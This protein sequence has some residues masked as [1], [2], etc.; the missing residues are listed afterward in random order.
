MTPTNGATQNAVA[1][2]A[3]ALA[4]ERDQMLRDFARACGMSPS[5]TREAIVARV[6]EDHQTLARLLPAVAAFEAAA[7]G[8]PSHTH[9][10]PVCK[11]PLCDCL[12]TKN[13][14]C[15]RC[16]KASQTGEGG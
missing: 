5:D 2:L 3:T 13:G 10:R 7:K 11:T 12:P 9:V 8:L 6:A 4:A 1:D 16:Y 14:L 15:N